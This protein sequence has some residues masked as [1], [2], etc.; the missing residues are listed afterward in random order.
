MKYLFTAATLFAASV[1]ADKRDLC[2]EGA[3]DDGGN[4]YCQAV[5]ALTYT[6]V[7]GQGSYNRV[8]NMNPDAD[9]G[10][11]CS[12]ESR[13][14]SGN[15]SPLDE[16]VS[17]HFRGPLQLK[18][19][20]VYTPSSTSKRSERRNAHVRRHAH[21]HG[22]GHQHHGRE[23]DPALGDVVTATIDG[24]VQTWLNN[25]SGH[26]T[27]APVAS[28]SSA[29]SSPTSTVDTHENWL[30]HLFGGR[31]GGHGGPDGQG[32]DSSEETSA[33]STASPSSSSESS[34]SSSSS[35]G[36]GRQAYYDSSSNTAQGLVFLNHMGGTG[37][38]TFDYTFGNSLSYS[39]S[40]GMGGAANATTLDDCTLPSDGEVIIMSDKKCSG[41][42]CGYYRPD[43][44]AHHGFDGPSKAFFFEFQMP[45][46]GE[47]AASKYDPVDMPA[48]WMLNAQIPRTL[49][50][51]QAECSCWESGCGEFDI[52]EVLAPGDKRCKS[53]LHG[54]IAGGNSDYIKRPT[55]RPIKA[56]MV[57]DNNNIHIKVLEDSVDFGSSMDYETIQDICGSTMTQSKTVSIFDLL[58]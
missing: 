31:H 15:L 25:W 1:V 4:W 33:P 11:Q 2:S 28:S 19:F 35:G 51:G 43:T 13:G 27:S 9:P 53:T 30:P 18:Q 49:Q 41:D 47:T 5:E 38:G 7:G 6:G 26:E 50:Y 45:I 14:Y 40:D 48:I 34:S 22:H 39:A 17:M 46:S 44:V 24:V 23:A 58:G 10:S 36:W 20:A 52:F 29:E 56:A 54:N 3:V 21:G 12:S 42:D 57:L 37:S 8:T 55:D 16:E 32:H